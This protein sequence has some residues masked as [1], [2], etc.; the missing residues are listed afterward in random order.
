MVVDDSEKRF[1]VLPIW[2]WSY[3]H[4]VSIPPDVSF[5]IQLRKMDVIQFHLKYVL[6][7]VWELIVLDLY[8]GGLL[9]FINEGEE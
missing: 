6:L 5:V 4:L 2:P 9:T 8:L 3:G 1:D 7:N